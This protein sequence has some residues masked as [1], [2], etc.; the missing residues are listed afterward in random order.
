MYIISLR[1]NL[2]VK[3]EKNKE[4][5]LLTFLK[6]TSDGKYTKINKSTFPYLRLKAQREICYDEEEY[7]YSVR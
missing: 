4:K 6:Q 5:T 3:L 1:G 2:L 7:Y